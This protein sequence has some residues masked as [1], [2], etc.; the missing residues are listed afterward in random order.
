MRTY[1]LRVLCRPEVAVGFG[2]AGLKANEVTTPDAGTAA[3][4]ELLAAPDA[5]VALIEDRL[6]D[7]L[8][9]DLRRQL[10]RRPLPMLVPFPGPA[11]A[12]RPAAPEAYI[13]ELLRQVIGY[14]VRLR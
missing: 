6:Y 1:A 9:D 13:V 5:G 11:W 3:V 10:G 8:P 14:R 7:A 4:R 2:L 12:E